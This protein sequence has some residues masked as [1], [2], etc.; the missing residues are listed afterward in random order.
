MVSTRAAI[1]PG[2]RQFLPTNSSGTAAVPRLAGGQFR[3]PPA[4]GFVR[5]P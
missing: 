1:F 4:K 5:Y 2:C 3:I